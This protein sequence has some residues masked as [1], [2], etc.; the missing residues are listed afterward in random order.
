MHTDLQSIQYKKRYFSCFP[1]VRKHKDENFFI[2]I[3]RIYTY[4]R[5]LFFHLDISVPV[6]MESPWMSIWY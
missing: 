5:E 3:H 6:Q 1:N 2:D 4:K